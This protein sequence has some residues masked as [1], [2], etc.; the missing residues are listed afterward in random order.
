MS[1]RVLSFHYVL[2]NRSGEQLDSSRKGEPFHVMEGSKQILPRLEEELFKMKLGEKKIVPLDAAQ[3]YGQRQDNLKVKVDRKKLPG[4]D[5]KVGSRFSG[6][7]GPDAPIFT[8]IQIEGETVWLDGNHPLAG[9]DLTFEVEVMEIRE[10]T[11]EEL[12][13]GHAHG[14]H[15][16]HSH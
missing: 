16:H 3:A 13:H 4:N 6:G 1:R 8:V 9:V 12:A 5:V 2:T 7:P 15:G 14:A 11:Q 10:A